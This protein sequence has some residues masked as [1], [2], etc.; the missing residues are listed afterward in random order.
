MNTQ[1]IGTRP[2]RYRK[3]PVFYSNLFTGSAT[4]PKDF[5][6]THLGF[7]PHTS[8]GFPLSIP[9]AYPYSWIRTH[10]Y[11]GDV[12]AE[13]GSPGNPGNLYQNSTWPAI[14][15]ASGAFYWAEMDA[16]FAALPAGVKVWWTLDGFPTW[17]TAKPWVTQGF[18]AGTNTAQVPIAPPASAATGQTPALQ[19]FI[20][21]LINRYNTGPGVGPIRV[22]EVWNEPEQNTADNPVNFTAA[23]PG[24]VTYQNTVDWLPGCAFNNN[25]GGTLPAAIANESNWYPVNVNTTAKTFNIASTPNGTPVDFATNGNGVMDVTQTFWCGTPVELANM[26]NDIKIAIAASVD[27]QV[28]VSAPSF[29][30]GETSLNAATLDYNGNAA[31]THWDV[32]SLHGFYSDSVP[33]LE[34]VISAIQSAQATYAAAGLS[35]PVYITEFGDIDGPNMNDKGPAWIAED[36]FQRMMVGASQG[37]SGMFW[38]THDGQYNVSIGNLENNTFAPPLYKLWSTLGGG[39]LTQIDRLTDGSINAIINGGVVNS[40]I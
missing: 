22:I 2:Y 24:V 11:Q 3:P 16:F 25:A 19:T 23:S 4:I 10:N 17:L 39:A 36:I 31:S 37:I 29:P 32:L 13:A 35:Q 21:T 12:Q 38:F 7:Y 15:Y 20:T 27:P 33:T 26:A 34:S 8:T 9:P 28:L 14:N 6:G 30:I 40:T 1:I 5:A 18:G